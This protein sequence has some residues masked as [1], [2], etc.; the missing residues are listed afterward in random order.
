MPLA[1]FPRNSTLVA[2]PRALMSTVWTS[3]ITA[4]WR[5]V[6]VGTLQRTSAEAALTTTALDVLD[7]EASLVRVSW[8]LRVTRA[9]TVSSSAQVTIG[10][11]DG[12][13]AMTSVAAAVTGNTVTSGQQGSIVV[14]RDARTDVTVALAYSS[15]GATTMQYDFDVITEAL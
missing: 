4:L 9:A 6:S 15:T 8:V 3:W 10:W 2:G 1:A 12:G 14:R 5:K 7:G 13:Q 11:T